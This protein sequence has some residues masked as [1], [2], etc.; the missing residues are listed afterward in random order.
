MGRCVPRGS[1]RSELEAGFAGGFGE[2][3]DP[4]VIPEPGSIEHDA[5]DAGGL[6]PLGDETTDHG[7]LLDL[8]R[9]GAAKLL[10]EGRGRGQRAPGGV[11]DD[12]RVDV[13]VAA[14]DR[15]TRPR[16]G[17]LQAEADPVVA[18]AS[19]GAAAGDLRHLVRSFNG[20]LLAA[21][22]AGLAGLAADLLPGVAAA[23]A[24][25]A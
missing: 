21:D 6:C 12:L 9:L 19:C 11:V 18:L 1:F 4:P 16:L 23:L 2:R 22:L 5:L 8:R 10:L 25:V 20:L 13:D 17:P 14:E 24:L 15:E 7:R 3:L